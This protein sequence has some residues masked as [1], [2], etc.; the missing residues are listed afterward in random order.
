MSYRT[1][2]WLTLPLLAALSVPAVAQESAEAPAPVPADT[3]IAS[4]NGTE[5][6][7]GHMLV[8]RAR[9]PQEYQQLEPQVLFDGILDQLIQQTVMGQKAGELSAVNRLL[10]DNEERALLSSQVI[11]ETARAATTEEAIQAAYDATFAEAGGETEYNAAHILVETE[12]EAK[13]I[14]EELA[15]GADFATLAQ[16]RS[17]GPSGPN[18]GDLGWFGAGMMVEPFEAAVFALQP[19]EI[20]APVQTQFGWHVIQLRE[21]R[22]TEAPALEEVRDQIVEEIQRAAVAAEV[23][24]LEAEADITRPAPG[25]FDP[26]IINDYTPIS[27]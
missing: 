23:A 10:L 11:A 17:V 20:S 2:L 4:V 26:N 19:G 15:A 13:A 22:Q 6:T 24:G 1:P 12:D 25:A 7:L 9:L 3:V 27:E 5:I 18:G 14:V 8:L 21:T 16:E